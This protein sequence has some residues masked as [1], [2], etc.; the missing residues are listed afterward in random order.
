[1]FRTYFFLLVILVPAAEIGILLW[2]GKTIGVLPTVFFILLTGVLGTY[3]AKS[4]GLKVIRQAQQQMAYGQMPGEAILDGISVLV[5]G[6]LLLAP[7]FVTDL[8]GLFLLIPTTRKFFK[9]QLAASL[10]KWMNKGTI[11]I[12]R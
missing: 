6:T 7:G 8:A 11:R 1:M 2:S 10:R 12:I 5:G 9:R 3:L 4:Q